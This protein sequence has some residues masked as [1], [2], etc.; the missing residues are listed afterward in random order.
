MAGFTS[1]TTVAAAALSRRA[2]PPRAVGGWFVQANERDLSVLSG[3]SSPAIVDAD[4]DGK[5]DILTGNTDG[6]IFFYKNIGTDA[7]PMFGGYTMVQSN[8]SPH[9][10]GGHPAFAAGCLLLDRQRRTDTGTFSSATAT[11]RSASIAAFRRPAISTA[12]A[13][14]TATTSR[15]WCKPWISRSRWAARPC[16]L[17]QDGVVDNLDLRLFADLWLAEH[18]SRGEV[19]ESLQVLCIADGE[20]HSRKPGGLRWA[21]NGSYLLSHCDGA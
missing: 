19:T 13:R 3:R 20:S 4:G 18:G 6:Q 5:K 12:T 9:R 21:D 11:A 10:L 17:N 8:G 1:T 7:L 16:D 14:S 2:S 15:S